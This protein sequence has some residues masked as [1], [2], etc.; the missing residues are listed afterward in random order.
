MSFSAAEVAGSHAAPLHAFR[1]IAELSG[2]EWQQES[3]LLLYRTPVPDPVVW[4]GAV[5]TGALRER[6]AQVLERADTFFA[7]HAASYGFW[8]VGSRDAELAEF[9]GAQGAESIDDMPHMVRA[10]ASVSGTPPSVPVDLVVDEAGRRAFVDV[11]AASFET[12][13][14]DPETWRVV[15]ASLESLCAPDV[16]AVVATVDGQHAGAA[17]GYL[18]GGF[19]EVIHVATIPSARRR[20][21]GKA[22]T[23]R[24]LAE[25]HARGADLAALQSTEHGE[26]VYRSLGFEEIDRYSLHLRTLPT[27]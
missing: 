20:G 7:P 13:G 17:M 3:G 26:G 15:Y 11:A 14:A 6:P 21:V 24:V 5:L 10:A 25:A 8:I 27:T 16:I 22:V 9:L 1:R 2:G 12:I 19:C 23:A 4:N 18:D